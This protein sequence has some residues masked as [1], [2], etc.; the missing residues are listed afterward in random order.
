MLNFQQ[1]LPLELVD[2]IIQ[3]TL[4]F[5]KPLRRVAALGLEDAKTRQLQHPT[6]VLS[7]NRGFEA[8]Y[9]PYFYRMNTF[10]VLDRHKEVEQFA[11]SKAWA[12]LDR[13]AK[14]IILGVPS[15]Y[16][17]D[18]RSV[19]LPID[20][21]W[22]CVWFG[23]V[24][25]A[26]YS[27][28][29]AHLVLRGHES[30]KFSDRKK[31]QDFLSY[32]HSR[33]AGPRPHPVFYKFCKLRFLSIGCLCASRD[34]NTGPSQERHLLLG[35]IEGVDGLGENRIEVSC[36]P[37]GVLTAKSIQG[38]NLNPPNVFNFESLRPEFGYP[39][40]KL[41]LMLRLNSNNTSVPMPTTLSTSLA[42]VRM[43]RDA[44]KQSHAR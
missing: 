26:K 8:R 6:A 13:H 20:L 24:W 1:V 40:N 29:T 10:C 28:S 12:N 33:I 7:T 18:L 37:E 36:T 22:F 14:A 27:P 38:S 21:A 41:H 17:P 23:L 43:A 11:A 2:E 35:W 19:I 44:M 3:L 16:L 5:S 9:A 39:T 4:T 32:V 31:D 30:Q 25:L 34:M 42:W 15:R